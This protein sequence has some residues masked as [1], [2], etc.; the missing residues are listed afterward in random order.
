MLTFHLER[1][2]TPS[3]NESNT[4]ANNLTNETDTQTKTLSTEG[5]KAACVFLFYWKVNN[6]TQKR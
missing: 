1:E 2:N 3:K 6:M 5:G 4:A